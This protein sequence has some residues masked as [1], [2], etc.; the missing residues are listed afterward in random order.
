M[1]NQSLLAASLIGVVATPVSVCAW[2][3]P[4]DVVRPEPSGEPLF[5]FL[6]DYLR[7][8]E[9]FVV[10][11]SSTN[12]DKSRPVMRDSIVSKYRAQS[13]RAIRNDASWRRRS[14]KHKKLSCSSGAPR[15]GWGDLRPL[16]A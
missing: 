5:D 2:W 1:L 13:C 11:A 10:L 15:R 4:V 12:I 14:R 6:S 9:I 8:V 3:H 7:L 16:P